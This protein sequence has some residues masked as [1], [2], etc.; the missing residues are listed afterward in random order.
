MNDAGDDAV[1]RQPIG[2]LS[3]TYDRQQYLHLDTDETLSEPVR[4]NFRYVPAMIDG[5]TSAG[6]HPQAG[7]LF[8]SNTNKTYRGRPAGSK[9]AKKTDI[10]G[11]RHLTKKRA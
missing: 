6:R 9:S 2:V 11:S 10:P 3:S 5:D 8:S 1:V 4:P 7:K